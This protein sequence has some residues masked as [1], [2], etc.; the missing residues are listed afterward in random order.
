MFHAFQYH[1]YGLDARGFHELEPEADLINIFATVEA[2]SEIKGRQG[3]FNGL[4]KIALSINLPQV[5]FYFDDSNL[6]IPCHSEKMNSYFRYL[7][8]F[9]S[10]HSLPSNIYHGAQRLLA[11]RAYNFFIKR[12]K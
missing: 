2:S 6:L 1:F 11:P 9:E 10:N 8:D 3:I 7:K 5:I 4:D 12:I